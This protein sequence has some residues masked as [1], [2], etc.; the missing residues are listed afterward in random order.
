[1]CSRAITA[2]EMLGLFTTALLEWHGFLLSNQ[3]WNQLK[4]HF[5]EAY[6]VYLQSRPILSIPHTGAAANA[7]SIDYEPPTEEEDNASIISFTNTMGSMSMANSANAQTACEDSFA[8]RREIAALRQEVANNAHMAAP[9]P[10]YIGPPQWAIPAASPQWA[11]PPPGAAIPQTAY[12]AVPPP[13]TA[14][15]VT[16]PQPTASG[17]PPPASRYG[18]Y[19]PPPPMRTRG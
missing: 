1:M 14:A 6:G 17:I 7:Q 2:I 5:G 12:A 4:S 15:Y 18:N 16:I 3:N 11:M 13:A 9:Q 8:M 19:Q 10:G